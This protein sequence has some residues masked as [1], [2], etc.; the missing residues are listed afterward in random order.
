MTNRVIPAMAYS[1]RLHSNRPVIS[2]RLTPVSR[3]EIVF[4]KPAIFLFN[5]SMVTTS[6]LLDK[7]HK[8][9][10]ILSSQ[11]SQGR[12]GIIG[13]SVR[14]YVRTKVFTKDITKYCVL[15]QRFFINFYLHGCGIMP[16]NTVILM[17]SAF[18]E[19]F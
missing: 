18:I 7:S 14:Y 13:P 3:Y 11:P 12:I 8:F 19:F 2:H 15:C 17:S 6:F 10:T 16:L 9:C 1:S 4:V 5:I